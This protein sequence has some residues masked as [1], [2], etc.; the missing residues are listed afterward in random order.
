ML[1]MQDVR[2]IEVSDDNILLG[3]IL[4]EHGIT[5]K[6]L[7]MLTGRAASTVYRYCSG[8]ATIPSIV[9][10]VLFKKTQDTRIIAL[11]TGDMPLIFVPLRTNGI[12]LDADALAKMLDVRQKQIKCEQYV[13]NILAD[14]KVD[15]SDRAM[16]ERYKKEFPEMIGSQS[17]VFQAITGHYDIINCK[18]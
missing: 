18:G 5:V 10:R 17:A 4:D 13:L 3:T 6:Q 2:D 1:T 12:K 14:G 11:V 9:W 15:K 7:A 8:E 16:I